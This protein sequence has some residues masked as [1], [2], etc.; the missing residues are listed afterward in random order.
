MW[1]DPERASQLEPSDSLSTLLLQVTGPAH[2]P[3]N[4]PRWQELLHGYDVWVH[5]E[6]TQAVAAAALGSMSKHASTSSNLAALCMHVTRMIH[7]LQQATVEPLQPNNEGSEEMDFTQ[8]IAL[9]A[10]SRATAGALNLLRLFVHDVIAI[11]AQ[12]GEELMLEIFLY[13]SRDVT[14]R[15]R[16]D[17][18]AGCELIQTVMVFLSSLPCMHE[19]ED[20]FPPWKIVPELYDAAILS[21]QLVLVLFSTQLYQLM[22]SSTQRQQAPNH[23]GFTTGWGGNMLLDYLMQDAKHA[24]AQQRQRQRELNGEPPL[25]DTSQS[26][27]PEE[28]QLPAWTPQSLLRALLSW[29]MHRPR[30]P[31]RSIAHHFA[32]LAHSVVQAKGEKV[33]PDGMFESHLVVMA[34]RP[35]AH[36]HSDMARRSSGTDLHHHHVYL[37]RPPSRMLLAATKSLI[38]L[39]F[40]LVSLAFN[41]WGHHGREHGKDYDETRKSHMQTSRRRTN[42]VLWLTDSPI[43][44]LGSSLFLL[45]THNYRATVESSGE[46]GNPF[47]AELA[48]LNDSRWET[49]MTNDLLAPTENGGMHEVDLFGNGEDADSLSKPL[50]GKSEPSRQLLST[51]FESLFQSFGDILHTEPGALLLYTTLQASPIFAAFISVRS[52]LDTLVMPILRTLYFSSSSR[53]FSPAGLVRASSNHSLSSNSSEQRQLTHDARSNSVLLSIRS[54]PFRSQSQ[55]Y[56][57]MILLLI[58]SQDNSFGSDAFRR[59]DVASVPWYKE[60]NL[61][62]VRLG[63]LLLL[64]LLRSI[65]FNL[66]KLQDTFLLSN[67]CAVLMNLSPNIVDL[68]DYVS[69][70]L[71]SITVSCMKRY[72]T[73]VAK[74]GGKVETEE[75][76][77]STMGMY[78]EVSRTLLRLLRYS[79]GP[80]NIER[81]LHVVY[82]LVYHQTD[83]LSMAAKKPCPFPKSELSR[84]LTVIKTA[85]E[86]VQEHGGVRTAPKAFHIL[87]DA[88]DRL[89]KAAAQSE[90]KQREDFTFT[91]E[92]EADPEIFFLPYVWEVVVSVVTAGTMDWDTNRIQAFALLEEIEGEDEGVQVPSTGFAQDVSDVV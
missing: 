74:N 24:Q 75:D 41:L 66:N 86:I 92:E 70:R 13:Q 64:T 31:P 26:T 9:V 51:N 84:L 6:P 61:K 65:I 49:G 18:Q 32:E 5:L 50:L 53:H 88:I 89:Q 87:E 27:Q 42:D 72:M 47:R 44:D 16:V 3:W 19:D 81:N 82:A 33:G 77:S 85:A 43:A 38:L 37:D 40:R 55:L 90:K 48:A 11:H 14:E 73:L 45:L 39:P 25:F 59:V 46:V 4:D 36:S 21:L 34:E 68:P 69:M 71:V 28:T 15:H 22:L 54:C 63:S 79:V 8:K 29:Q 67:C 1:G 23:T 20:T 58:F 60:R 76:M 30:A 52:D 12:E 91:Y 57:I 78:G 56:V 17:R 62:D 10:K 80:K 35:G 7:D 83:F 2:I